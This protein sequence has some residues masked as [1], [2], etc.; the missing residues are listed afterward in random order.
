M[1]STVTVRPLGIATL[2]RSTSKTLPVKTRWCSSRSGSGIV[3]HSLL[4]FV[5]ERQA[6]VR[7]RRG[8]QQGE[9]EDFLDVHDVV[10]RQLGAQLL[11]EVLFDVLLV[12]ARQDDLTDA[13]AARREHLLLDAADRQDPPRERNL[14]GH[15]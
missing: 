10:N 14:A 1:T 8:R 12:L 15:R 13:V 2:S 6:G 7:L 11:G 4:D 5:V 3:G 9:R